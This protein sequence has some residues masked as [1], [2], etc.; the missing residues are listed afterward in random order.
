MLCIMLL[1]DNRLTV[2]TDLVEVDAS[3]Q[4]VG[5]EGVG[6]L[7]QDMGHFAQG[8]RAVPRKVVAFSQQQVGLRHA[9]ALLQQHLQQPVPI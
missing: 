4:Q 3:E 7:V 5:W 9:G 2:C 6:S 1:F 8:H